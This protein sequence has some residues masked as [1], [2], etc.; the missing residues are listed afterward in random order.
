ML[1]ISWKSRNLRDYKKTSFTYTISA[2][3]FKLAHVHKYYLAHTAHLQPPPASKQNE[4]WAAIEEQA[5]NK[6]LYNNIEESN[7]LV[8]WKTWACLELVN[9]TSG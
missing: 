2:C 3:T 1:T 6:R 8:E 4:I 9:L 7:V 5:V